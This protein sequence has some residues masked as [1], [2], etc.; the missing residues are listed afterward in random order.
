VALAQRLSKLC[1]TGE[2]DICR[3]LQSITK[4]QLTQI[5]YPLD[6]FDYKITNLATDMRDGV[7]LSKLIEIMSSRDDCSPKLRWPANTFSQRIQNVSIALGAAQE[8]GIILGL[9]DEETVTARD[10]E[11]GNREKTL[12]LLWCLIRRWK[13]PRYLSNVNLAGEIS[14]LENIL[15]VRKRKLPEI[16]VFP[17]LNC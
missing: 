6:D 5:Q 3:R 10:I 12:Y 7:R 1:L 4:S 13:L 2:G 15:R 17:R 14:T 11:A 16:N 9:K 8:E